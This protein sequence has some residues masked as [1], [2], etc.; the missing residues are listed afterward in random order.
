MLMLKPGQHGASSVLERAQGGA[1]L[2]YHLGMFPG[3]VSAGRGVAKWACW[4]TLGLLGSGAARVTT[5]KDRVQNCFEGGLLC[6]IS[7]LEALIYL[8]GASFEPF[9]IPPNF[10]RSPSVQCTAMAVCV[11]ASHDSAL[12]NFRL[13]ESK[14]H[15]CSEA[16]NIAC[17]KR[18]KQQQC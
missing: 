18:N 12:Y 5:G 10:E 16:A 13:H 9:G 8:L 7:T 6:T 2:L 14:L 4:Q 17:C 1:P 11:V 3:L 15:I